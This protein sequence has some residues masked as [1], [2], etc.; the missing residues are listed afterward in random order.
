MSGSGESLPLTELLDD[1][2]LIS[3]VEFAAPQAFPFGT[4]VAV[5]EIDPETGGIDLLRMAVVDD[6]GVVINPQ[7]VRGQTIGSL[8]QGIGQAL[9]EQIPYDEAGQPLVS[10]MMDYSLPTLAEVPEV[11][12]GEMVTPNPNVPLGTKGAG[13]AGCIGAPPAIVNAVVDALGGYDSGIDMPVTP[14]KVW[15]AL[16]ALGRDASLT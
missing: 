9:F 7:G 4:Y 6:C 14:E 3:E 8:V 13:E 2:P 5:V 16:S 1:G 10:T 11:T 12:L 15:R